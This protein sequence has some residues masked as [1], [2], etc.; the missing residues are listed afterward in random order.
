MLWAN[1]IVA[2]TTGPDLVE[3]ARSTELS[4]FPQPDTSADLDNSEDWNTQSNHGGWVNPEDLPSMPQCISSQDQDEWLRAM[5][6]CTGRRCTRHFGVIC[7]H[8]QWLTQLSCLS[9]EFSPNFVQR[10]YDYCSRSVLAK[11]QFYNWIRALTHRSWLVHL[12]DTNE[13]LYLSPASLAEGYASVDVT[14]RAPTCLQTAVSSSSEEHYSY[15]IASCG[16]TG[17]TR[18]TG[19][20]ARP[21]E[22]SESLKSMISLDTETA[23]YDLVRSSL[24]D[25][26][27]F[28]KKC[29]CSVFTIE[30]SS[31]PCRNWGPLELTKERLWMNAI[32]GPQS[33][34]AKWKDSSRIAGFPYIPTRD[35]QWPKCIEDIPTNITQLPDKCAVDVC[36]LDHSG[37]CQVQHSVDRACFC[38][39][40]SYND[41][42]GTCQLFET[43]IDYVKWLHSLCGNVSDW[44]GLPDN[45][46]KL[47]S[48]I[49]LD[50]IPWQWNVKAVQE[51][52]SAS[53]SPMTS[54]TPTQSSDSLNWKLASLLFINLGP[55]VAGLHLIKVEA[56][57][58]VVHRL[59]SQLIPSDWLVSGI[60]MAVVHLLTN[61]INASIVQSTPGYELVP[62]QE[63]V[64]LWCTMPRPSWLT[65]ILALQRF[66]ETFESSV[67]AATLTGE[68]ILQALGWY[69]MYMTFDYGQEH[70]LYN[71]R[72]SRISVWK[73]AL[74]VYMGALMWLAVAIVAVVLL[75]LA[76]CRSKR[77]SVLGRYETRIPTAS[78]NMRK[79]TMENMMGLF[80]QRWEDLEDNI[81]RHWLHNDPIREVDSLLN[82][83]ECQSMG[84]GTFF[85]AVRNK[86]TISKVVLRL[87]CIAILSV[88]L[89]WIAQWLFWGGFIALAADE[90]CPPRLE[91]L[92]IVWSISALVTTAPAFYTPS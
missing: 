46:R 63:L 41:C 1:A 61:W 30:E 15:S 22:Y 6:R 74:L 70:N 69:Y 64:L 72:M 21:W 58:H 36:E 7:T 57:H 34:P 13:L 29:F 40:M 52:S 18:H 28:D 65:T 75:I 82:S 84:Y 23:G 24:G 8:H 49:P 66:P 87:V 56:V 62:V 3:L 48:V 68:M 31:E 4:K 38:K 12:G 25:W 42:G 45:W 10:Y 85:I 55:V 90:Y 35:W 47:A 16:F 32:C 53:T 76:S 39:G 88:F 26:D 59:G 78:S 5:T 27:Y 19:N 2:R 67:V 37:F 11:A 81:A 43:R 89:L 14:D 77:K 50:L 17:S 9:Q 79:E 91:I 60:L 80:N 54:L 86:Q 73:S 83:G 51:N 20:A 44:H 33:L 92:T 71:D